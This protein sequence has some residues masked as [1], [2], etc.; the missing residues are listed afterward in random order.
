MKTL[1]ANGDS[2][3]YGSELYDP[4]VLASLDRTSSDYGKH[5]IELDFNPINHPY[6]IAH[7]YPYLLGQQLGY[8]T[9]NLAMTADN[10]NF[11]AERTIDYILKNDLSGPNVFVVVGWSA[12]ERNDFYMD[13]GSDVVRHRIFNMN[14]YDMFNDSNWKSHLG[15]KEYLLLHFEH[16]IVSDEYWT[17]YAK[18]VSLLEMF[19][20]TREI[21]YLMFNAFYPSEPTKI[22]QPWHT[23]H[24]THVYNNMLPIK[25][26]GYNFSVDFTTDCA[27][28]EIGKELW[29]TV[30]PI[31]WYNKD[32]RKN[33]FRS[34]V[35]DRVTNAFVN[36][37]GHP[38]EE[39]HRIWALEL[40]RYINEHNLL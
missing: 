22:G 18:N 4:K 1:I 34:F 10:N 3:T 11:I 7:S 16:L 27:G 29:K 37:V 19:L 6:R 33:S 13:T 32:Q 38:T 26:L 14:H 40:A 20:K 2:W 25:T 30:D 5:V 15:F 12:P 8:T 31:R 23:L 28:L 24:D 39:S 35:A 17:R 9:V 36:D 21:P